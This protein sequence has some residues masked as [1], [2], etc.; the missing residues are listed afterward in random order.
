[1]NDGVMVSRDVLQALLDI[2]VGGMDYGS[3][4]L[5]DEQVEALRAAAEAAGVPVQ[6]V[7]PRNHLCKYRRTH[8]VQTLTPRDAY[9]V[10]CYY[11]PSTPPVAGQYETEP[12]VHGGLHRM[13]VI[14]AG[15]P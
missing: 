6:N 1:M 8:R 4:F 5:D 12:H 9:C 7:T 15:E 11:R 10:D 3:G 2:V 14:A 13:P